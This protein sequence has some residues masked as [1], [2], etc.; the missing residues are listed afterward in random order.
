MKFI[1]KKGY[2]KHNSI[3]SRMKLYSYNFKDHIKFRFKIT[4]SSWYEHKNEDS[5]DFN[6]LI[7]MR[8][9][10]SHV[11]E[12]DFVW[13]PNFNK[14]GWFNVWWYGYNNKK[15]YYESPGSPFYEFEGDTW[16]YGEIMK[17][18]N[19]ERRGYLYIINDKKNFYENDNPQSIWIIQPFFGGDNKAPTDIKIYIEVL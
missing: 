8:W 14:R 15:R 12:A 4:K 13:L 7:G 9:W 2:H 17:I 6:K 3:I 1:I 16:V 5:Y 18:R 10:I 11:N 19:R